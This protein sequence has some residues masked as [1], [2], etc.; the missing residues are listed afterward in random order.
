MRVFVLVAALSVAG[1]ASPAVEQA[2][3]SCA[4]CAYGAPRDC[5]DGRDRTDRADRDDRFDRT[6]RLNHDD[7]F[8]RKARRFD[9]VTLTSGLL[10][11][12]DVSGPSRHFA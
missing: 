11:T 6:D 1:C 7:A 8:D 3:R 10:A 2:S 4:A 9:L 5:F 12:S